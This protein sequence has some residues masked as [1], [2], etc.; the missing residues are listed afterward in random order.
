MTQN[1]YP[2]LPASHLTDV[3]LALPARQRGKGKTLWYPQTPNLLYVYDRKNIG[4]KQ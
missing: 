2:V 4:Q 1:T 3:G